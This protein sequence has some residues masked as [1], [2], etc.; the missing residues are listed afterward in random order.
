M[1][2]DRFQYGSQLVT[3]VW[4]LRRP[5]INDTAV[6]SRC[7]FRPCLVHCYL[8]RPF[9]LTCH[10]PFCWLL[11]LWPIRSRTWPRFM[12]YS[13]QPP[14][15]PTIPSQ[16]WETERRRGEKCVDIAEVRNAAYLWSAPTRPWN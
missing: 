11:G 9:V 5:Q 8:C 16:R 3:V 7:L 13:Y 14:C 2:M 4:C 12:S 15:P 1:M 6:A 10:H